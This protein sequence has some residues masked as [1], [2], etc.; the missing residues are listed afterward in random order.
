MNNC[1]ECKNKESAILVNYGE[2]TSIG[3][4]IKVNDCFAEIYDED[5]D[6]CVCRNFESLD[7]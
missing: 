1:D 5:S 2:L 4:E 3:S 6:S 7:K